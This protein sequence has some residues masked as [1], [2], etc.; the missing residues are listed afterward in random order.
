M[1]AMKEIDFQQAMLQAMDEAT[2][3]AKEFP[4]GVRS[5]VQMM[6]FEGSMGIMDQKTQAIVSSWA[7]PSYRKM[8]LDLGTARMATVQSD[9]VLGEMAERE[10]F[11]NALEAVQEFQS[12]TYVEGYAQVS[13]LC[14][15]HA[16][17]E[18]ENGSIIDPTWANS[19]LAE[20][21]FYAGIKF[22]TEFV[23]R[24]VVSTGW[25]SMLSTDYLSDC[26]I[27]KRG[28]KLCN[29]VAYDL[30]DQR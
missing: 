26:Q 15:P 29:G 19:T 11:S 3:Q 6:L 18:D 4:I 22:D 30:G 12:Y 13:W 2:A 1:E 27:L 17:L 14:T 7:Y 28:L 10:C 5:Q 21:A 9:E 24:H 23:L 25:A 20:T 8:V 16:W